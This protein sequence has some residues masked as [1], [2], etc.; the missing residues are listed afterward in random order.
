[1]A[2]RLAER[3]A[4]PQS[5]SVCRPPRPQVPL[6]QMFIGACCAL[7]PQGRNVR[8]EPAPPS[9]GRGSAPVG[10]GF[11]STSIRVTRCALRVRAGL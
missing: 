6:S 10:P 7:P 3:K 9:T 2:A 5:L 11:Q 4:G 1:M 8:R